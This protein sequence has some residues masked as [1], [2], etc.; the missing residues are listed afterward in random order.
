MKRLLFAA[1]AILILF[2]VG[3]LTVSNS[4]DRTSINV[5]T[6]TIRQDTE[7]IADETQELVEDAREGTR[8]LLQ[9]ADERVDEESADG[10]GAGRPNRTTGEPVDSRDPTASEDIE[11][12]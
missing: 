8:E 10:S 12:P 3:W 5:E 11:Q 7:E 2:F 9:D 1:V 4:S 6:E